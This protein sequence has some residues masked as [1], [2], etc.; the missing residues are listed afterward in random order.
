M[1]LND[2]DAVWVDVRHM[3]MREAIDKL[4]SDFNKFLQENTS[5]TGCFSFAFKARSGYSSFITR[6]FCRKG[7]ANLESMRD[8]I[9]TLPQYQS[10]LSKVSDRCR[11]RNATD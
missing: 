1:Q 9:A 2:S 7:P 8:M 10:Q 5:F 4:M 3:H 11:K 6:A